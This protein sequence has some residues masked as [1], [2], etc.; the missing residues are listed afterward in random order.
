MEA[1]KGDK[2]LSEAFKKNLN[3]ASQALYNIFQWMRLCPDLEQRFFADVRVFTMD[4][5]SK[6]VLLRMHRA[7]KG[8]TIPLQYRFAEVTEI[9]NYSRIQICHIVKTVLLDYTGAILHPIIKRTFQKVAEMGT[10]VGAG[11][12]RK[13]HVANLEVEALREGGSSQDTV[14]PTQQTH[15]GASFG[16]ELLSLS[17]AENAPKRPRRGNRTNASL[18]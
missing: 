13:D 18:E 5:N 12:K 16:T 2:S 9:H 15:T 3:S 6:D 11:R 17:A 4:I 7:E 10:S 1:K 8:S 14:T